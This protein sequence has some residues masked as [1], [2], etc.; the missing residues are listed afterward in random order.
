MSFLSA[1]LEGQLKE[2]FTLTP[3]DIPKALELPR[4][5]NRSA[6]VGA[7]RRYANLLNAPQATLKALERL[8]HPNA[9]AVVTGQQA[10]LLLGP[11]YTLSKAIIAINLAKE[12][13]TEDRPVVAIFWVASQDHDV[14]EVNHSYVLDMNET[15]HHLK[16]DLPANIPI[17]KI[18]MREEWV[19][20]I[21]QV[22]QTLKSPEVYQEQVLQLLTETAQRAKTFADW[23]A[24]ILYELLGHQGL[25]ILNPLE[26]D[27]AP[28]FRPILE[29]ELESPTASSSIIN[30]A[31]QRLQALGYEPQ[32]NRAEWA[33]NLFIEENNQRHLL[34]FDG[35]MFSTEMSHYSLDDLKQRLQS[36]ATC[37]TPAAGL[38]PIT[39]DSILPTAITV[40]GPGELRYFAQLK[41]VY[42]LHNVPISL[43]WPRATATLL[44][45]P[46]VRIMEKFGLDLHDLTRGFASSKEQKLL[47]LHGYGKSFT[48]THQTLESSLLGLLESIKAIDPTLS[49]TL[50]RS[51]DHIR[52]TLDILK[53]KTTKALEKQDSITANQFTRLEMQ[54]FPLGTPQERL[55][56][57]FSFFLKFGIESVITSLL[58]LPTQG[59]HSFRI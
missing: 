48:E 17:G 4:N 50:K 40:L 12:L 53:H 1:Y 21:I 36:D 32:L 14:E 23:F 11:N 7:L 5:I 39:Q 34:K 2:F 57:P 31:G 44:E 54:L 28:L 19:Q 58:T 45:P 52:K 9:K 47:D 49:G 13:S 15:L 38:R 26:P 46:V 10:G 18:Q 27:I 33:T 22:L 42:E 51:E 29:A 41:G 59:N 56:S 25:I 16:V 30:Q 24:A 35:K 20:E 37:I 55:I 8:E 3:L 6:L 43:C